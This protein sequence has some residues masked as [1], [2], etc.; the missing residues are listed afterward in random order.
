MFAPLPFRIGFA[1]ILIAHG[2]IH[3]VGLRTATRR[4]VLWVVAG[5]GFVAAGALVLAGWRGW[6]IAAAPT[7]MLSQAL[8]ISAFR[9]AKLGTIVNVVVLIPLALAAADLRPGS[10]RSRYTHDVLRE[11]GRA[12]ALAAGVAAPVT[13]SDLAALPAP[14]QTWLR[15]AG[16]V[17]RPRV[18][19]FA[20][21][22]R[23]EFRTGRDAPFMPAVVEQYDLFAPAAASRLFF[24]TAYRAGVP[25]D[26][27]HRYADGAATMQVRVAGLFPVV[28]AAG[29]EMTRSETV[30]L[31]NDLCLLAPAA[32][33]D[34][35]IRWRTVD[36]HHVEATYTNAGQTVSAVLAFDDAGD[37]ADFVSRD[38]AQSDGKTSHLYPWSTPVRAIRQLNGV[39]VAAEA[40]ALWH[41]PG[42]SWSYGR[43]VVERLAYE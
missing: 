1:L 32:V 8:I 9:D 37:L 33:I 39:R 15:R 43:F 36:S 10:L 16:V 30:T 25:F 5:L 14:A 41:E 38:R 3:G 20:A 26:A 31:L 22:L 29:P 35:P 17:G 42:G 12:G 4:S 19:S 40:E 2:L 18:R 21:R 6:W 34:A 7:L 13:E 24:M 28:D 11:R 23:T 27:F